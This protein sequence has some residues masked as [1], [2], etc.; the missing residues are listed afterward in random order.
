MTL[1]P[2]APIADALAGLWPAADA[3][4]ALL[5][6]YRQANADF[7]QPLIL[8][9]TRRGFFSEVNFAMDAALFALTHRRR[10]AVDEGRF[11]AL[12]WSDYFASELPAAGADLIRQAPESEQ[13]RK[14]KDAAFQGLLNWVKAAT[15]PDVR[16]RVDV[17]GAE[18]DFFQ[19]K[20][21]LYRLFCRPAPPIE[22]EAAAAMA[23]LRLAPGQYAAVHLRRGDK[24]ASR[25][26]NGRPWSEG[27]NTPLAHI[28]RML[29]ELSPASR[30]VFLLTDDFAA[31][32]EL[33]AA[34]PGRRVHTLCPP[35]ESGHDQ[36][37][38]N[39]APVEARAATVRRLVVEC[40]IAASSDAFVGGYKSNVAKFVAS[41]HADPGRCASTDA[42][43]APWPYH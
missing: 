10:L 25:I 42:L 43:T 39:A 18:G 35:D 6:R 30:D 33:Q 12:R 4:Q 11:N 13:I 14:A 22:A 29:D 19:V 16:L 36:E 20:R 38:F 27:E 21:A 23:R 5:R 31:A 41:I 34:C 26:K 1:A 2:E 37:R 3:R 7:E 15:L 9:L 24:V 40:L 17:L 28:A 8:H 32:G